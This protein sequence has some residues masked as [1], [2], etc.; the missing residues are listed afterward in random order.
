[1]IFGQATRTLTRLAANPAMNPVANLVV[2]NVPGPRKPLFCTG[3]QVQALFPVSAVG[4]SLGLNIT[5][6]SYLDQLNIGLLADSK[7]VPDLPALGQ[8]VR[9]ELD[10]LV[11]ACLPAEKE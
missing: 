3:C 8:A 9:E 1:M 10:L 2:S 5:F 11:D 7:L 6:F 4:D